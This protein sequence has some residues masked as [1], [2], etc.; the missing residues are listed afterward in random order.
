MKFDDMKLE[1][2]DGIADDAEKNSQ[3][4]FDR[5]MVIKDVMVAHAIIDMFCDLS[6][7]GMKSLLCSCIEQVAKAQ[8]I[9]AFEFLDEIKQAIKEV[10]GDGRQTEDS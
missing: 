1:K 6:I 5:D 8:G 3:Q 9:T 7:T 10:R 4:E 2:N